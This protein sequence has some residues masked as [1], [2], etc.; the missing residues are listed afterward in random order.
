MIKIRHTIPNFLLKAFHKGEIIDINLPGDYKGKW[1]V[2]IF[3]P[4]D[5]TYVCPTE[6][7]EAADLYEKFQEEGAE[8]LSVSTDDVGIHKDWH[9]QDSRIAKINFPMISDPTG[10]LCREFGTYIES[11]ED[12]GACFRGSFIIDPDGILRAYEIQETG[13]GRSTKELLRKLQAAIY[14]SKHG[15]EVCPVSWEPGEDTIKLP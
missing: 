9:D 2:L 10:E 11:G 12:E 14:V 7:E 13:F 8:L 15:G 3:Y 1:M 6:L 4:R 5:F